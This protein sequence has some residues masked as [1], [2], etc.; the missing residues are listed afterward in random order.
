MQV[1]VPKKAPAAVEPP[2]GICQQCGGTGWKIVADGGNGT[3]VACDCSKSR[4]GVDLL[5]LAQ[6]PQRYQHCRLRN[7][8]TDYSE[9]QQAS[10]LTRAREASELYVRDFVPDGRGSTTGGLIYVGPPG[11]GKTHLAA[12]VLREL[13]ERY[14]V[15]GR[16]AEFTDLLHQIQATF[17]NSS[18]RTR[19]EIMRP[20]IDAEILVLDELGAQKPSQWVMDVLYLIIN[21]RY[22]RKLPTLFTSNFDLP[23]TA[24]HQRD[25]SANLDTRISA[26]LVSRIFEMARKVKVSGLDFRREVKHFQNLPGK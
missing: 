18:R 4:R 10:S 21:T 23:S 20:V 7:F 3:A 25:G 16:F 8:K 1:P 11:V 14:R 15:R 22:T 5:A 2:P 26:L 19:E 24:T 9:S 12:A 6:I 13:V 17:N